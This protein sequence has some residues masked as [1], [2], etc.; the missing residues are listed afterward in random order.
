[1]KVG[2]RNDLGEQV[3]WGRRE[4]LV[5][6]GRN[7]GCEAKICG[8]K[9]E[10][11]RWKKSSL[12]EKKKKCGEEEVLAFFYGPKNDIFKGRDPKKMEILLFLPFFYSQPE[13][14]KCFEGHV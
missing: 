11:I 9:G 3:W 7:L 10:E 12:V 13:R 1:M 6:N 5:V 14:N 2:K 8:G 4:N